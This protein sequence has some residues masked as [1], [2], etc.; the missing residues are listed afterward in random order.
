MLYISCSPICAKGKKYLYPFS[1][2]L[3]FHTPFPIFISPIGYLPL[4]L[5]LYSL[6]TT[7]L[8]PQD[9]SLNIMTI[10]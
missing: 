1:S 5:L 6:I 9:D 10:T 4:F 7:A 8:T 3:L 2:F